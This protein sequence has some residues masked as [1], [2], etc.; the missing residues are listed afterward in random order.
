MTNRILIIKV[1]ITNS[2]TQ[3]LLTIRKK[4]KISY[5]EG[6]VLLVRKILKNLLLKSEIMST[7][8]IGIKNWNKTKMLYTKKIIITNW[9]KLKDNT[10]NKIQNPKKI[11]NQSIPK[12]IS[13]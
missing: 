11:L 1:E 7:N 10:K 3:T 4:G 6:V 2:K 13:V 9:E 12:I 8:K 5:L